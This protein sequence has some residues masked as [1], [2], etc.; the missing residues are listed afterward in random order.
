[1]I[2]FLSRPVT[3]LP[4]L[5]LV[6]EQI[7]KLTD[8]GHE[9]LDNVPL[10]LGILSDFIRSTQPGIEAAESKVKFWSLC[11]TLVYQKGEMIVR[12]HV[13]SLN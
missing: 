5:S 13:N 6:L 2:T 9:D 8:E 12:S 11:E 10:I 4:R 1:L 3:R 7:K